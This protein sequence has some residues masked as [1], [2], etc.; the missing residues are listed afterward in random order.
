MAA[1]NY[2]ENRQKAQGY[3]LGITAAGASR[4]TCGYK[5]MPKISLVR[6]RMVRKREGSLCLRVGKVKLSL[7][8]A[9]VLGQ[10]E[11]QKKHQNEKLNALHLGLRLLAKF[12][13]LVGF[14][15]NHILILMS[16]KLN[17]FASHYGDFGNQ[18]LG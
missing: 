8:E 14:Q 7:A 3:W 16:I 4:Q 9:A 10:V 2:L 1:I 17:I 6:V 11:P 15:Q 12:A 13:F 5:F 18:Q